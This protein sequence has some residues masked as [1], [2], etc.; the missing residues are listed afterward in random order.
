MRQIMHERFTR[1]ALDESAARH[2][3][4]DADLW[5]AIRRQVEARSRPTRT[6]WRGLARALAA[7]RVRVAIAGAMVLLV[8]S[9]ALTA[10]VVGIG[11][12]GLP[13]SIPRAIT[14]L[15]TPGAA[16]EL[17]RTGPVTYE[18]TPVDRRET[19]VQIAGKIGFTPL[20]PAWLPTGCVETE[21]FGYAAHSPLPPSAHVNYSC[22]AIS[23][24]PARGESP[25]VGSSSVQ[26]IVINGQPALYIRGTWIN[27]REWALLET[28]PAQRSP[29]PVRRGG[30]GTEEPLVWREDIGH[31]L[32]FERD[33]LI[34]RLSGAQPGS[35]PTLGTTV[36][37]SLPREDLIRIAESL[38]PAK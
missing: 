19:W 23:Q 5:P 31:M 30:R 6:G 20:V 29:T 15:P 3:P 17:Q 12:P 34:I 16:P 25:R 9:V 1:E 2:L 38:Q 26:E 28:P 7:T 13:P 27:P 35:N 14:P 11:R 37:V 22:V 33:G 36:D 18:P 4:A 32:V 10:P 21:R 8:L 24:E